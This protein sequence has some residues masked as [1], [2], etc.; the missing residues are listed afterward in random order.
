MRVYLNSGSFRLN[1]FDFLAPSSAC[2]NLFYGLIFKFNT[3]KING[4]KVAI[5]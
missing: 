3:L 1:I 5:G 4:L 2:Y